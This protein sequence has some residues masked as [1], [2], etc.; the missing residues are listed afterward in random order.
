MSMNRLS[1]RD[2]TGQKMD[3]LRQH[4]DEAI[5]DCVSAVNDFASNP[6]LTTAEDACLACRNAVQLFFFARGDYGEQATDLTSDLENALAEAIEVCSKLGS[7][8]GADSIVWKYQANMLTRKSLVDAVIADDVP[9][10]RELLKEAMQ[11]S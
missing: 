11:T 8:L 6:D 9:R 2:F 4:V 1:R 10:I 3:D 7:G 5:V